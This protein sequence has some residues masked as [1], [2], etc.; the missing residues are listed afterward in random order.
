MSKTDLNQ[1][2]SIQKWLG[3]LHQHEFVETIFFLEDFF[4]FLMWT[5]FKGFIEFVTVLLLFYLLVFL[6]MRHMGS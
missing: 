3:V 2:T 1:A 5:V 6:A 4:F